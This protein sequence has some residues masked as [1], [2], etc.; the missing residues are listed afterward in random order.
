MDLCFMAWYGIIL[1]NI[2]QQLGKDAEAWHTKVRN[3]AKMLKGTV[4]MKMNS[5]DWN[6]VLKLIN[7]LV[8]INKKVIFKQCLKY[9]TRLLWWGD[10]LGKRPGCFG[11]LEGECT[12]KW[13]RQKSWCSPAILCMNPTISG[14]YTSPYEGHLEIEKSVE[15]RG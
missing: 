2:Y 1:I 14:I 8:K 10:F 6:G 3:T 4:K 9:K 11:W 15:E 13:V 12:M 7:N 5:T